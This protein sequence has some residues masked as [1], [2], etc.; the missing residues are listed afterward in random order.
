MK[1]SATNYWLSFKFGIISVQELYNNNHNDV[2]L[3]NLIS[4]HQDQLIQFH[5]NLKFFYYILLCFKF[6]QVYTHFDFYW[7]WIIHF[8]SIIKY[9]VLPT[10]YITSFNFQTNLNGFQKK[11]H[12]HSKRIYVLKTKKNTICFCAAETPK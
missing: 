2:Y 8:N 4:I 9:S 10:H 7:K 6:L 11:H 12:F 3:E 1:S 5:L